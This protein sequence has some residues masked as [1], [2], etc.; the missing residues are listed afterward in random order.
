[1]WVFRP[2][3]GDTCLGGVRLVS[4][5]VSWVVWLQGSAGVVS[6]GDISSQTGYSR[7]VIFRYLKMDRPPAEFVCA[8]SVAYGVDVLTGLIVTGYITRAYVESG[9]EERLMHVPAQYL[10]AELAR[11]S[12]GEHVPPGVPPELDPSL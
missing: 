2:N 7:S 1:M 12:E 10:L 5:M 11:R 8:L 9:V 4:L 3:V 6:A